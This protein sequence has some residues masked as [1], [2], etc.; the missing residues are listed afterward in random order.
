MI[1]KFDL[2]PALICV[3][4]WVVSCMIATN[5][6]VYVLDKLFYL[7]V[8]EFRRLSQQQCTTGMIQPLFSTTE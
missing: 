3:W 5:I 6:E 4:L 8:L 2:P 1:P 7:F